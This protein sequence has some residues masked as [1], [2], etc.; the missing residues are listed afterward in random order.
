[1]VDD[2]W[3]SEE[4]QVGRPFDL[5]ATRFLPCHDPFLAECLELL[6]RFRYCS[7]GLSLVLNTLFVEIVDKGVALGMVFERFLIH[8]AAR[9][10]C[11]VL[12]IPVNG[13]TMHSMADAMPRVHL[14]A[15]QP[16][17]TG[18]PRPGFAFLILSLNYFLDAKSLHAATNTC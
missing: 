18:H 7:A 9:S 14:G 12:G 13:S 17:T 10:S 5:Y 3:D 2:T 8:R 15:L 4:L 1:M 6:Q 11:D 16:R